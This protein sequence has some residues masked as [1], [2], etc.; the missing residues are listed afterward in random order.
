MINLWLRHC[1]CSICA[2]YRDLSQCLE[3][4]WGFRAL[5]IPAHDLS[6]IREISIT[7][8]TQSMFW[9]MI[10]IFKSTLDKGQGFTS[11]RRTNRTATCRYPPAFLMNCHPFTGQVSAFNPLE[12]FFLPSCDRIMSDGHFEQCNKLRTEY[13]HIGY[14]NQWL[15]TPKMRNDIS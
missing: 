14:H 7:T 12:P 2:Q 3:R 11:I 1:D 4:F 13:N 9:Y 6:I 15:L 8:V 5:C 10:Y